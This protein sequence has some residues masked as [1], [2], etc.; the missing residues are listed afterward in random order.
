MDKLLYRAA[1]NVALSKASY[2]AE[3]IRA[4]GVANVIF[5]P[6]ASQALH[7]TQF[8]HAFFAMLRSMTAPAPE[9]SSQKLDC[10]PIAEAFTS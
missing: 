7:A 5:Y 2:A 4:H 8:A 1:F 9:V 6:R 10:S 3:A